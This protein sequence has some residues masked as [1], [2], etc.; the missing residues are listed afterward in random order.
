MSVKFFQCK[1]CSLLFSLVE[2]AGKEFEKK[3]VCPYCGSPQIQ[4]LVN[5]G[6]GLRKSVSKVGDVSDYLALSMET[7]LSEK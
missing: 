6:E 4:K 3:H 1:T 7:E 2:D 5:Y